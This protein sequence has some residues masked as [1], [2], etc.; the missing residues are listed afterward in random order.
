MSGL[1]SLLQSRKFWLTL[2]G[3]IG[4]SVAFYQHSITADMWVES[5][6]ALVGV[7]V[8]SIAYEDANKPR[9]SG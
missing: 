2:L 9:P 7:L 6:V 8:V 1:A 4:S 5:I 3:F